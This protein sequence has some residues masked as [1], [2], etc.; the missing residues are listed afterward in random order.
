MNRV[1][2]KS[3]NIKTIGYDPATLTLEVE[4]SGNRVYRYFD[5]PARLHE[6]LMGAR[7]HG[8]FLWENISSCY[9]SPAFR[10][11]KVEG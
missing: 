7:S 11:E 6:D 2:V 8:E 4:F 9:L 5:I 3:T 1:P 10:Y